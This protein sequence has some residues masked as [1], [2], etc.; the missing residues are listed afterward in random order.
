MM[1]K[2]DWAGNNLSV[3]NRSGFSALLGG[4]R[5]STTGDFIFINGERLQVECY[6]KRG[7]TRKLSWIKLEFRGS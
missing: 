2:T 3:N 7:D 1:A 4:Y 6:G 5:R